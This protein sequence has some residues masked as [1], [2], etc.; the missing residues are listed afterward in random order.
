MLRRACECR[1]FVTHM[2]A[3]VYIRVKPRWTETDAFGDRTT[4]REKEAGEEVGSGVLW[5]ICDM[6]RHIEKFDW[7]LV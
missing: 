4:G 6:S 3:R 1:R 7:L 5:R 2:H